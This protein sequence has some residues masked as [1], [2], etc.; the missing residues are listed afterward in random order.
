MKTNSAISLSIAFLALSLTV[1]CGDKKK[2]GGDVP[3]A[4]QAQA[5]QKPTKP[6]TPSEQLPDVIS[7]PVKPNDTTVEKPKCDAGSVGLTSVTLLSTGVKLNTNAQTIRYELSVINC[8][9]GSI[10]PINDQAIS[11]D[12][13]AIAINGFADIA[14]RVLDS[15]T[16]KEISVGDLEI[17]PGSDLF[18]NTGNV[19]HWETETLSYSTAVEKLILEIVMDGSPFNAKTPTATSIASFLK[20][21]T[22]Q[23]VQQDLTITK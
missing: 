12:I 13:D 7:D 5:D 20:V 6:A 14:Y 17:I 16:S 11:F 21:G 22:S 4:A 2:F 19:A 3:Q 18:G 1:A 15:A 10:L 9:D 8:A 23:A